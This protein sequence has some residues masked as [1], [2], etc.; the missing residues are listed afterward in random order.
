[1]FWESFGSV[2]LGLALAW[3]ALH[4]LPGRLPSGRT[5]YA[6]GALGTLFGVYLT[7][8]TLGSGHLPVTLVC[9]VL[10]GAIT[11]S[12]LIRPRARRNI[13]SAAAQ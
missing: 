5:V 8:S 7:R 12:L 13:R 9:A 6:A 1:M 3:A 11:L 2:V 10:V 4:T